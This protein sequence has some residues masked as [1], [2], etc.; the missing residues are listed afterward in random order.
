MVMIVLLVIDTIVRGKRR[1]RR[2]TR[3]RFDVTSSKLCILLQWIPRFKSAQDKSIGEL[4]AVKS[5]C[6]AILKAMY[7]PLQIKAL[8]T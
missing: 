1:P 6:P 7:F 3:T 5:A 8:C 2:L 4:R